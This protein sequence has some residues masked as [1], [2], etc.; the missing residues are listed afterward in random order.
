LL[1]VSGNGHVITLFS[2]E[3]ILCSLLGL[4]RVENPWACLELFN[5]AMVALG[6]ISFLELLL[7]ESF[8]QSM[9]HKGM[10]DV[11]ACRGSP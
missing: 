5:S 3:G 1:V 4:S 11:P 8:L 9:C 2:L 10:A 7:F 6:L